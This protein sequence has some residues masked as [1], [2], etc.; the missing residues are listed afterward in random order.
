MLAVTCEV[1]AHIQSP[2][3]GFV[4]PPS[5]RR[6]G[7][8]CSRLIITWTNREDPGQLALHQ[9][10]TDDSLYLGTPGMSRLGPSE[11]KEIFLQVG[12]DDSCR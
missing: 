8:C 1:V 5:T 2:V 6:L 3:I 10:A 7:Y 12:F 4:E 11:K 9:Q